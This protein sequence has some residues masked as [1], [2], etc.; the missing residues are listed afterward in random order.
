MITGTD[1]VTIMSRPTT[2]RSHHQVPADT[3]V[4][5]GQTRQCEGCF[6]GAA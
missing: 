2:R 6:F 1:S 4:Q 3:T 5:H